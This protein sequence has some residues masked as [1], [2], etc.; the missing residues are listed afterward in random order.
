[1]LKKHTTLFPYT[2]LFRS[3]RESFDKGALNQNAF[4]AALNDAKENNKDS[5]TVGGKKFQVSMEDPM[6]MEKPMSME[7]PMKMKDPMQMKNP[8]LKAYGRKPLKMDSINKEELAKGATEAASEN[9]TQMQTNRIENKKMLKSV[10]QK[11]RVRVPQQ[12][13][14]A[15][16]LRPRKV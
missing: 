1:M 13:K 5:F 8:P 7:K 12:P 10:E 15:Q 2:T 16:G 4:Y 6:K 11:P 14:R 9:I 3:S